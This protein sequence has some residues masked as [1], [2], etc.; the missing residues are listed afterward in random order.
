MSRPI[1]I[2]PTFFR[3]FTGVLITIVSLSY[4]SGFLLLINEKTKPSLKNIRFIQ[5]SNILGFGVLTGALL[6]EFFLRQEPKW[7][8][9]FIAGFIVSTSLLNLN[10]LKIK[11]QT[12]ST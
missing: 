10:T 3:L 1:G 9:V 8:L 6:A 2:D 5:F 12:L 7:P 4:F 11:S